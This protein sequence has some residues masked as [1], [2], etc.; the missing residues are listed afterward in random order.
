MTAVCAACGAPTYDERAACP[1][2][3]ERPGGV[4]EERELVQQPREQGRLPENVAGALAYLTFLPAIVFLLIK[5][6]NKNEFIRFHAFQCVG[7][8]VAILALAIVCL[9]LANVSAIN[10]L[11]IPFSIILFIGVSLLTL[12]CMIKAFQHQAFALPL[13]GPWAEKLSTRS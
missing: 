7:L 1:Q 12:V 3:G 10:L 4:M 8:A 9:P 11:L 6:Y 13:L 2:C 5:P